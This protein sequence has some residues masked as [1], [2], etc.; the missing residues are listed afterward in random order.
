MTNVTLDFFFNV[1]ISI[2]HNNIFRGHSTIF[3]ALVQAFIQKY[4]L[5]ARCVPGTALDSR[6]QM[7][8]PGVYSLAEGDDKERENK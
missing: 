8:S 1:L 3:K 4:L 5:E 6:D 7:R 2:S